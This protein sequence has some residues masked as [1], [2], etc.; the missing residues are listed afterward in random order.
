MLENVPLPWKI[1][2]RKITVNKVKK[3]GG[4]HFMPPSK[5][6]RNAPEEMYLKDLI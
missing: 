3:K 6:Q 5:V 1:T 4:F 2:H